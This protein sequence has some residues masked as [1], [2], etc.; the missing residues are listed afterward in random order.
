M[1]FPVVNTL[2]HRLVTQN[3]SEKVLLF[4]QEDFHITIRELNIVSTF[5]RVPFEVKSTILVVRLIKGRLYKVFLISIILLFLHY[6][7]VLFHMGFNNLLGFYKVIFS[8]TF[9]INQ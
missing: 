8:T 6:T 1:N 2:S 3:C 5:I 4:S 7:V 9:Q